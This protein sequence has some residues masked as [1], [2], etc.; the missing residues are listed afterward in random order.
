MALSGVSGAV[1][2][3]STPSASKKIT[4]ELERRMKQQQ[5]RFIVGERCGWRCV[6]SGA[7]V[8]EALDA[9]HLPGR[10]W[11]SHN[12][13]TDGVLLRADLHKLVDAGLATVE[14]GVFRVAPEARLGAYAELDG[15]RLTTSI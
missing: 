9:A 6:V 4:V 8:R 2:L 14:G 13:A 1:P 10:N 5:F 15:V 7:E 12:A 3:A 11:R